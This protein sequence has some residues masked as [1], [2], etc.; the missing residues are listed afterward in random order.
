[1]KKPIRLLKGRMLLRGYTVD[2]W[3]SKNGYKSAAV[4]S[5]IY[6]YWGRPDKIPR[7][8]VTVNILKQLCC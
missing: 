8:N 2:E 6:R 5:A 3:A 1:M 7:G 4:Y